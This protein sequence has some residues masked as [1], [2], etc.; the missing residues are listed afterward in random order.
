MSRF[1][2]HLRLLAFLAITLS[3]LLLLARTILPAQGRVNDPRSLA[4]QNLAVPVNAFRQQSATLAGTQGPD[5][6]GAAELTASTGGKVR[7]STNPVTGTASF[8]RLLEGASLRLIPGAAQPEAQAGAFWAQYGSL[9]GIRAPDQE[10]ALVE[11][12]QDVYGFTHLKYDQVYQGVRVFGGELRVH[13]D[14]AQGITAVNGV[15]LPELNLSVEPARSAAQAAAIA[16][17]LVA[18]QG[19]TGDLA[20]VANQLVVYRTGLAQR[21]SGGNYLAYALEIG[22][23]DHSVR[24]F[25]F[26]D[27]QTGKKLDQY[28][29]VHEG[30]DRKISESTL[31]NVVW[32][33]SAGNPDPIPAGWATGT[34]Q[35]VTDWQNE[36][37]GARETYNLFASMNGG[38]YL[39]Y[40]GSDATMRTVNNDPTINCPNA[41]W[42][43]VSTNYC[44]NVTG[45]D[46]VA[47]EWGHAYTEYTN[48]LVYAWQP[49]ALNESYSD[50]WGEVVDLLNGRGLDS[51]NTTRTAG[52][53][54]VY[55]TPGGTD[56]TYRWLSGEDDPAF[57]GAIR[58]MW[59]PTCY[60]DPGKVSDAQYYCS[61]TDS[62]G[63]HT[64]SGVPNHAF[65]LMVDGGTYNGQTISGIGLTKA[66]HIEWAAQQML[67]NTSDF[68]DNAD[69]LEAACT[70]LI[71]TNLPALSTSMTSAGLSGQSISAGDCAEV[72]KAIAAVQFRSAPTQCNF[73][74]MLDPNPPALCGGSTVNALLS[75]DWESGLGSWTVGTHDV[76][77]P[78]SFSSTDWAVVGSLPGARPGSAAFVEDY[79]GGNC[80]L[81]NEAG[82]L[83]LDSPAITIPVGVDFPA[84]TFDHWVSTEPGWDG[85]NLK[86]SVNGSPFNLVPS[87]AFTFNPYNGI[88]NPIEAGSDNPL[89]N[90]AAFSGS[91]GGS[92][93]GSWGT[94]QVDLSGIAGPGDVIKL[95]FDMGVDGCNG[96]FGWYVDNL[97]V[98]SCNVSPFPGISV[99]PT[100]LSSHQAADEVV[101]KNLTIYNGGAADL[102]WSLG[103][104]ALLPKT[105]DL[106]GV[107]GNTSPAV[108]SLGTP[109]AASAGPAK[110]SAAIMQDGSF[111][112]GSP[113][114]YWDES[115]TNFGTPLC[116]PSCLAS[117]SARTGSW[118]AWFGGIAAQEEGQVSQVV[119]LPAGGALDL[120]FYLWQ[121]SC[122]TAS[123]YMEVLVDGN[124]VY[125]IDGSGPLCGSSGYE[126]QRANLD[127]YADGGTHTLGFHSEIFSLNGG[128]TNFIIDD[129][130]IQ[131][132][133]VCD[134]P[135][136]LSWLVTDVMTGTVSA[137]NTTN[138][139]VTFDSSGLTD[140]AYK[141]V[142]CLASND[143]AKP[144]LQVPVSMQ[145][146]DYLL[147][148]PLNFRP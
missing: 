145:I 91:D 146:G 41:N 142:L 114:P 118:F 3:G 10:L 107:G 105:T 80:A 13:L 85:G 87:S 126:L 60:S 124:Q 86:I 59:A 102:N 99:A 1:Y 55:G 63:V 28:T 53:C 14:P 135:Q 119:T 22:N 6:P 47:H 61:S 12:S 68:S 15:F 57:G 76:S 104:T 115:S 89:Q 93:S 140:G 96:L 11:T 31:G 110:A 123:D 30:L 73:S 16:V 136:D 131:S 111:E 147:Y 26:I 40:N 81:D 64:N 101:T 132:P 95:R 144:V 106:T 109:L 9:F 84:L 34:D 66:A 43:G 133:A 24:E 117:V 77:N 82:A 42:S 49:G 17:D 69:A 5:L 45:D 97:Q 98:Y 129:L 92:V 139:S 36:I 121:Q 7:I 94:S 128:I 67:T 39:S 44:S 23:A 141:G 32:Q 33:D 90:Q 62:G 122:D 54:S 20:V 4:A 125:Q 65:A 72:A 88:L 130:A 46:T 29:G 51:P 56:N 50:I 134:R 138:L 58:D 83:N 103:E 75:Q 113:N 74:P 27:A 19:I 18:S 8:V 48:N 116:D 112:A 143:P 137:L 71:G 100:R 37:D 79:Q 108:R 21:I 148:M 127:A 35:Q 120:T 78:L 52:T 2:R 70:A 38:S 25:V